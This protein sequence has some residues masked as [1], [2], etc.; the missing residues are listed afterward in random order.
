MEINKEEFLGYVKMLAEKKLATKEEINL[1]YDSGSNLKIDGGIVKKMSTSEIFYYIGGAI[2]FL[3]IAILLG[4]NWSTLSFASKI[5]STLGIGIATY[6]TG[7]YFSKSEKTERMGSAFHLIAALVLPMGLYVV[8]EHFGL[9][10]EDYGAPSLVL[11]ILFSIYLISYLIFRKNL[12]IYFAIIF[13]SFLFFTLTSLIFEN[14]TNE[15]DDYRFLLLGIVYIWLGYSFAKN[16]RAELQ[17]ELYK[18]GIFVILI[19]TFSLG[20]WKPDQNIFW[21]LIY[22]FI[23]FGALFFSVHIKSEGD[24]QF[25]ILCLMGYILKISSEYFSNSLGWPLTLVI[26]GFGM[27]GVGYMFLSIKK[28]YL[29]I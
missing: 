12:F 18:A 21:E 5:I 20:G 25:G 27:I 17:K 22:P 7:V 16:D 14:A 11:G 8:F 23:V 1:A 19:S 29:S 10:F 6:F 15:F 3:G 2:V 24:L 28:K 9:D 4:D 26:S 13:G